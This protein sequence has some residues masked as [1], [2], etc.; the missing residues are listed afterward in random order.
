LSLHDYYPIFRGS[1]MGKKAHIPHYVGVKGHPTF[2]LSEGY[3]RHVLIVYKP[4]R[5][6]PTSR[7]WKAEFESFIHSSQCPKS[8]KLTYKRVVQRFY[9]GTKFVEP[10]SA[11]TVVGNSPISDADEE[12]LILAGLGHQGNDEMISHEFQCIPRGKDFLWSSRRVVSHRANSEFGVIFDF[13]S[14]LFRLTRK[15]P[16]KITYCCVK[17][18]EI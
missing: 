13:L 15:M 6:Y 5:V 12:A 7:Y 10:I 9:D 4:W 17:R 2:P 18:Y 3:A 11:Q 8:A 14:R 1:I 16:F